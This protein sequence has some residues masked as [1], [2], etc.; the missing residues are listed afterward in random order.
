MGSKGGS[1]HLKRHPAPRFWPIHRKEHIWTVRPKPGPHPSN[2]NIPL[3]PIIRDILGF[4]KTRKEAKI[5]ISQGKVLVDGRIRREEA[6]PIGLMD[7]IDIPDAR[8]TYRLLPH[9]KGLKLHPIEEDESKFKLRRIENKT[10]V[11]KGI[12]LNFH[13]GTNKLITIS[14]PGN[15]EEDIYQ[16]LDVLKV[17]SP[18]GEITG[19]FK[20]QKNS[21]ALIIGGK[22]IGVS[23]KII[24]IEK[25]SGKRRRSLLATIEDAAGKHFQ[26][27]LDFIFTIGEEERSISLP[28]VK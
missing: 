4:A 16:T 21:I 12:Q 20:L 15:P 18:E 5:I 3:V 22:N 23:G 8:A 14:D 27:V 6:F 13:D 9:K 11:K 7:I 26:T 19:Q 1:R 28:E 24:E 2:H 17:S 25:A 10:V